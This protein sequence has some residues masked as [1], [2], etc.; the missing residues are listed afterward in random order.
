M[1]KLKQQIRKRAAELGVELIGTRIRKHMVCR[2]RTPGRSEFS[3]T[4]PRSPGDHRTMRNT[5]KDLERLANL[6]RTDT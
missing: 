3:V 2:F 6:Y 1:K 4:F 5:F